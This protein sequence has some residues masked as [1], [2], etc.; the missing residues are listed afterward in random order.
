MCWS[1]KVQSHQNKRIL[2]EKL[3]VEKDYVTMI[4]FILINLCV[5]HMCIISSQDMP[6]NG[7]FKY[8]IMDVVFL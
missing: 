3:I 2:A 5:Y 8:K 7:R 4:W 6:L 1:C